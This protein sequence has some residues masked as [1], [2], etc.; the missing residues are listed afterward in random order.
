MLQL[1]NISFGYKKDTPI[2]KDINID[3]QEG[4]FVAI[5][6]R[7]GA[8]KTT[9]TRL[10]MGLEQ[11][12]TGSIHY[13]GKDITKVEASKRGHYIGYVFQKP[14]RQMFRNTVEEEIAFG[15]EQLGYSPEEVKRLTEQAL[16]D[17]GIGEVTEAYPLALRRGIKQRIAIAS[18]LAMQSKILIL[19]E[20]TSGQD[21]RETEAL[22][23][24]LVELNKK[25]IT[26]LLVTHQMDIVSAYCKRALVLGYGGLA[27]DGTPEELFTKRDD[28][29][30]LGLV[31][32][33]SVTLAAGLGN[34][35]Y[36]KTMQ[37]FEELLFDRMGGK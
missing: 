27:F 4:E 36:C 13:E 6:G 1:N 17:V 29:T 30:E 34:M 7:N 10:I 26:I 14:D 19:D 2:L 20:P 8:G 37:E 24:L 18:A 5:C 22:L 21:G 32:P 33:L 28:L 11:P 25:G 3:I 35:P 9:L 15:P 31:K 16:K 23:N 12:N